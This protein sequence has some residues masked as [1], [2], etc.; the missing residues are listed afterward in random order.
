MPTAAARYISP[1]SPAR[2]AGGRDA[3]ARYTPGAKTEGYDILGDGLK[4]NLPDVL[5]AVA[6]AQL[7][8]FDELQARRREL[9]VRYRELLGQ[10]NGVQVVPGQL[11]PGSAD[12]LMMVL[13][14]EGT[15]RAL[16]Q[17][18]M[19]AEN[20]GTSVHF[21]PLHHFAWFQQQGLTSGPGG[22]PVAD[23]HAGRALSLPL[24]TKLTAADV[25]RVCDAL[26]RALTT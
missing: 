19:S 4:A 16:V 1:P 26:D 12:H 7:E 24:H 2:A 14:P 13:L 10:V 8:R 11:S 21:R 17:K 3:W 15:D 20:I 23:A 22:T 6:R 5:A 9:T 25:D 18:R